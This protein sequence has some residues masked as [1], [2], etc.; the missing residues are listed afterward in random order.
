MKTIH[1]KLSSKR[2]SRKPKTGSKS[3]NA[4]RRLSIIDSSGDSDVRGTPPDEFIKICKMFNFYPKIDYAGDALHH[5][6]LDYITKEKNTFLIDWIRNG[7]INPEYRFNSLYLELIVKM[8][9]RYD[10]SI[11]V[12]TYSKTG[13]G[14]WQDYIEPYRLSGE[15]VV[16]FPR[17]RYTFTDELGWKMDNNATDDSAWIFFKSKLFPPEFFSPFPFC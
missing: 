1:E 9:K 15:A 16:F 6:C 17:G 11:L 12:L 13:R 14:W 4:V 2:K 8:W 7:F 10:I 5:M 3:S